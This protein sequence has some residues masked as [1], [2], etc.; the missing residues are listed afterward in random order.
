MLADDDSNFYFEE[1]YKKHYETV[2]KYILVALNFDHALADD[3]LQDVFATV[4]AKMEVVME[5][6]NPGGFIVITARNFIYKYRH[7]LSL[8]QKY[9]TGFDE[10]QQSILAYEE[11]FAGVLEKDIDIEKL[12]QNFIG[13]LKENDLLLYMM[14]Y[15]KKYKVAKISKL[16]NITEN[17]VKVRLYRLRLSVK[18][19][20]R[21]NLSAE[22]EKAD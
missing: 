1:L 7:R 9:T 16:L 14:F 2:Y 19:L 11:D 20:V 13:M 12:K 10:A 5:H 4:Y 22:L 3:C 18:K 15:E 6:K 21:Q 17:S 8:T